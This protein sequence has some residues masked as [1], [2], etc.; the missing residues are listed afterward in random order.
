MFSF[1]ICTKAALT[2]GSVPFSEIYLEQMEDPRKKIFI[3]YAR[4]NDQLL[5]NSQED[6]GGSLLFGGPVLQPDEPNRS[7]YLRSIREK[8]PYTREQHTYS[9]IWKKGK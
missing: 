6:V 9:I 1:F 8:Q 5:S 3:A 7:R 4:G 2:D